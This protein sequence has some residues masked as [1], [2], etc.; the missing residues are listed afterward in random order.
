METNQPAASS[1]Y[2]PASAAPGLFGT[3]IP[4]SVAFAVGVLLFLLPIS[5]VR[6]GGSKLATKSGLDYA[7][8]KEWKINDNG[9]FGDKKSRE[10]N[11]SEKKE[12]QGNSQYFAIGALALGVIG[13]ILCFGS[14]KATGGGIVAGILA[15]GSAIGL[16]LDEKNNF[17]QSLKNQALDKATE[18]VGNMGLDKI[19]NTMGDIK[20]TLA[21]TPW[22]Y[23]AV[24]AFVAAALFCYMRMRSSKT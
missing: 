6:C 19:G 18:G 24:V 13:L 21:F 16:M 22:F 14:P 23:V 7:M 20:P 3:K 1:T 5:E 9:M 12:P 10:E 8:G 17:A 15:A 2:A 4:A 11:V